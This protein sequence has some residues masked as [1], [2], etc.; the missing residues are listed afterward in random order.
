MVGGEEVDQ[1]MEGHIVPQGSGQRA[2]AVFRVM[3]PCW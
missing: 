2:R 1:F 3:Y